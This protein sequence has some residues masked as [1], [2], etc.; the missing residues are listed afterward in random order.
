VANVFSDNVSILHG[1]GDG[2]FS[3]ALNCAAGDGA[4]S[5][6]IAD[7]DG[8]GDADLA[9][10][11]EFS[12]NVSVLLG[13][14]IVFTS[15]PEASPGES[16]DGRC[17]LLQSCPNPFN[18]ATTISFV[19]PSGAQ[20]ATLSIYGLSGELVRRWDWP[21]PDAGAREVLWNAT[22]AGGS[23]VASGIYFCRLELDD[24]TAVT[25]LVVLK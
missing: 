24:Q 15:V 25:K 22:D 18:P 12:D 11:N 8:D 3:S 19:V 14:T 4:C 23:G 20:M 6:A 13:N 7:L 5:V 10:A 1:R 21:S 17:A 9:V 16:N 2:T